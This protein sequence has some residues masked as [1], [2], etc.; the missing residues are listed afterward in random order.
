MNR[1]L[2]GSDVHLFGGPRFED[3]EFAKQIEES[4]DDANLVILSDVWLDDPS[5]FGKLR[6]LFEGLS[7]EFISRIQS[8]HYSI[9]FHFHW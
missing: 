2:L 4:S 8:S 6:E 7:F 9:C 3:I 1:L 5:V